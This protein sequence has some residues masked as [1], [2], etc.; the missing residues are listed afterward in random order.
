MTT[1]NNSLLT[2]YFC[3]S[4][5][6]HRFTFHTPRPTQAI[7][8]DKAQP[9][10]DFLSVFQ[11]PISEMRSTNVIPAV[12]PRPLEFLQRFLA[13]LSETHKFHH[14][15]S[16]NRTLMSEPLCYVY[17]SGKRAKTAKA[18]LESYV[19]LLHYL[20]AAAGSVA[21]MKPE[22]FFAN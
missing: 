20:L 7:E 4:L 18:L 22:F 19:D 17:G 10:E 13:L 11:T 3:P 1:A 2:P 6:Q 9:L 12:A 14:F 5:N 16:S 21:S 8:N 15:A